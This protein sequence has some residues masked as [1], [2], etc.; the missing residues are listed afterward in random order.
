[1]QDHLRQQEADA[2]TEKRLS[3]EGRKQVAVALLLLKDWKT[4]GRFDPD[5]T[6]I[7]LEL[8]KILGV[9]KELEEVM[10]ALPP[11]KITVR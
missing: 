4:D 10:V 9:S 11:M 7:I 5:V 2:V 6:M 8:A 1:L 3:E